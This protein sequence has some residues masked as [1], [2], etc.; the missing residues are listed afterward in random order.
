MKSYICAIGTANPVHK[1][2]QMQIAGFMADAL[3]FDAA[4]T[5]KLN[6]LYRISG[7]D[8]RYTVLE[9]YSR[10]NGEFSFFPNTAGL[11]P[12]PPVSQRMQAYREH[13]LPLSLQAVRNCFEQI[14]ETD[15][16]SKITH[17]ITVS[18]TGMYAPGLDIDLV[19]ALELPSHTERTSVN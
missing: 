14:P 3:Q 12:F 2:P 17:L 5:R 16:R 19:E 1:I 11:E 9:D 10:P 15:P 6:A 13:A 18:C 4:E 8:S 7:I